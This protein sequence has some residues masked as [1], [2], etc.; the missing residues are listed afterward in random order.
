[1]KNKFKILY[2]FF[3]IALLF[4]ACTP[5][6]YSLGPLMDKSALKFTIT[7]S[8]KN[9][10]DIVL[11]SLIP[12]LTPSWITPFGQSTKFIDTVN[13]PFPGTYK[14]VYGV[15]SDGGLVQADTTFVTITTIDQKA[16]SDSMWINLTGGLG[17]SKTWVYDLDANGVS[18][19][20]TCPFY[21]GGFN[22]DGITTWEWDPA[23]KDIGWSGVA[24]GDYGTMTF[25]LI[26]NANFSS[27]NK[28]FPA[29]SGTGTFM[30]Y[31]ATKQISTNGA[32]LLR[33]RAEGDKVANWYAK[34]TIK[35]LDADHL[36]VIAIEDPK[37]WL[38]YNYISLDYYNSH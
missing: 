7:P 38:I 12:K 37:N 9:P 4:T 31:P 29:L 36:Q 30:L 34:M 21:F 8:S 19:Y 20:F 26:G 24:A 17:K 22:A 1:M 28:M 32:Q 13:V 23:W 6:E 16:V 11:V 14:F 18:K 35:T 25:D 15:E 2:V 3:G 5:K 33:D 27:D 10:N